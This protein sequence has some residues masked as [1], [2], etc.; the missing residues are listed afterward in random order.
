MPVVENSIVINAPVE[1]VFGTIDDAQR[2]PEY[3]AGVIRVSE[4]NQTEG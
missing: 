1:K 4:V 3:F 2:F